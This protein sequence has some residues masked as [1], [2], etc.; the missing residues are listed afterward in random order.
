MSRADL[1]RCTGCG[2]VH[3]SKKDRLRYPRLSSLCKQCG[4][5]YML[6]LSDA[7]SLRFLWRA[8]LTIAGV[9]LL[10]ASLLV[11]FG[12]TLALAWAWRKC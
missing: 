1:M 8:R 3:D 6:P 2:L 9:W 11:L 7:E 12:F 5:M 10:N 4:G